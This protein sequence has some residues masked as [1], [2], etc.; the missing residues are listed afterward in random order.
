[1]PRSA[2][3]AAASV[4]RAKKKRRKKPKKV[5]TPAQLK[6][7]AKLK[8]SKNKK[9]LPNCKPPKRRRKRR[10]G[11]LTPAVGTPV[12]APGSGVVPPPPAPPP[13][14]ASTTVDSPIA[15]Y[16][17]EFGVAQAERLLW[18]AG[19][20]PRP[21]QAAEFAAMGLDRAV[22][23]LTRPA[24]AA[25][26]TGPAPTHSDGTPI[27]PIDI[28]GD[29]HVYWLDRM[30]RSDQQL[31]ERM[32]LVFHDWF[33]TSLEAIHLQEWILEQT[34]LFRAHSLGS[35]KELISAITVDRAMIYWL[36]SQENLKGR[37][38]ENYARELMELFTLGAD[39]GAYTENDVREAAR[40]LSGFK[41]TWDDGYP[42]YFTFTPAEHDDGVKTIFGQ[43]GNFNWA[44]VARMVVE[45]P[46]HPG[47][48]VTKLWSYFI[49]TPPSDE[50]RT[51]LE[52][53]YRESGYQ[54]RPV[55]EAILCSPELYLG[56]RMVK[57]P[58]VY[59]AGMLRARGRYIERS[60]WAWY[61]EMAGQ[62]LY[63][64]PD[65]SG[66]ND[67]RWLNT[68][69]LR[70]RWTMAS[71][72]FLG[73]TIPDLAQRTYDST[74]TPARSVQLALEFWGNPTIT[75]ETMAELLAFASK[76]TGS[77]VVNARRQNALRQIIPC[78][79]DYLTS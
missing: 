77:S 5:C 2:S 72:V 60:D 17:G 32:A 21:G 25:V 44:D 71:T 62:R 68:N 74:E 34:N 30:V 51:A 75:E 79:P 63:W 57:S 9:R 33:A 37:I 7:R 47:F 35:F 70:A 18:R 31:V 67:K 65:V 69:T 73:Q 58:V 46:M 66:W 40:A 53:R 8:R 61:S 13:P 22:T 27:S 26:L 64:P 6:K 50:T 24:G 54:I 49:P 52:R 43:S 28:G 78:T 15:K 45:H 36:S 4:K 10:T 1:M 19:F 23:R 55:L 11:P 59:N 3:G 14:P 41:A 42:A 16:S 38:N 48:F 76:Y 12:P 56:A 39:R 20:G 29:D